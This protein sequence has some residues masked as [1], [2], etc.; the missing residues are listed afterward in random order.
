MSKSTIQRQ[1][2][3]AGATKA[4]K[5]TKDA[6]TILGMKPSTALTTAAIVVPSTAAGMY[7]AAQPQKSLDDTLLTLSSVHWALNKTAINSSNLLECTNGIGV[8]GK[9]SSNFFITY[10]ARSFFSNYSYP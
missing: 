5:G 1:K 3:I 8:F 10:A 6:G 7:T 4:L 9:T 2:L